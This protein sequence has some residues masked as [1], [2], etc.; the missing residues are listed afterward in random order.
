MA[1]EEEIQAVEVEE[2]EERE[3]PRQTIRP[4][5]DRLLVRPDEQIR[6][7]GGIII[8]ENITEKPK[9]GIVLAVGKGMVNENGTRTAPDMDEGAHVIF[10]QFA[11]VDVSLGGTH[12]L[13]LREGDVLGVIEDETL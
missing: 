11:G 12:Y 10:S 4:L 2:E 7:I 5:G 13:I 9:T 6:E 3:A 1:T 8:P